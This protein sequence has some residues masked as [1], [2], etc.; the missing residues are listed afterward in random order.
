L[1][2][3]IAPRHP[4][5]RAKAMNHSPL[6]WIGLAGIGPDDNPRALRWQ[7]R[8]HWV[9][10]VIALLAL[11]AYMFDTAEPNSK[12]HRVA[13]VLDAVI[14]FAF[15]AELL[16]MLRLTSNRGR[17]LVENWL[18]AV[19]LLGALASVLGATSGW[20]ALVRV[21][22]VAL[23]GMVLARTLTQFR[24]LFTRRGAPILVG[25][26][27]LI[28]LSSGAM[29][30][31]LEPTINNYW[32]G[33]WLAFV[34]GT[35]IGYGDVVPTTG[36]S[37]LFA[38][39]TA[40]IGVSLMALFTANIVAFFVG[41]EEMQLRRGLQQDVVLLQQKIAHL[42]D[43]EEIQFRE[44]LHRD[45]NHLRREIAELLNAEELRIRKQ[46][47]HE[48]GQLRTEVAA[49]RVELALRHPASTGA[50]PPDIL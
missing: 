20:I 4:A 15:L 44:D 25:A 19:I 30:Y 22:R 40:L 45:V 36:A 38:A 14:F 34:T 9:M 8:L 47:Q 29:L 13:T 3:T 39:F 33:L 41:G 37:R 17:Y 42:L 27:F 35:T 16:W 5:R 26:A 12:W 6:V 49:L 23:G 18:N 21:V 48:I 31:W 11:P 50:P 10:V 1:R 7:T 28:M 2:D 46:F 24:V 32:D 43:S